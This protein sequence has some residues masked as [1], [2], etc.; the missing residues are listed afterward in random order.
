MKKKLD[1]ETVLRQEKQTKK[2]QIWLVLSLSVPAILAQITSIAMQYIDA[3]MVGN[4]GAEATAAIGLVSTSTW[5]VGGTCVGTAAGF[6]VQVAQ[7]VGGQR[8][9]E[10]RDVL[11]QG[12]C[13]L[14]IFGVLLAAL[15]VAISGNLPVW[16]G[17]EAEVLE[18]A[19]KYFFVYSLGIPFMQMR[20]LSASVMQCSGDM[21]TPSFL[22]G[23]LC[24]LDVIFNAFLIFPSRTVSVFGISFFMPG[25]GLRVVGAALGSMLSEVVIATIMLFAVC[26]RS[27]K[28]SLRQPGSWKWKSSTFLAAAKVTLPMTLD[29]IFVCSAYVVSTLIVAPLGT[30]AVAANSLAITA[31]SLVY[32]PGY[33][34]GSAATV[35]IG[36]TIGAKRRDLSKTFSRLS[37]I[38]GV[39]AMSALAV[40]MYVLAPNIFGLLTS[41]GEV[42]RLGTSVLRIELFVE[43]FYAAAICSNGV[44]RGAGDTLTPGILNLVSMWGVRIGLAIVLVP[45][46]GLAGYWIAMSVELCFR[47][48]IFVVRMLHGR[49]LKKA[50]LV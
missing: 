25:A 23:M 27:K 39:I 10:A 18:D 29:H 6:S 44:F 45:M 40:V 11:R 31:E 22:A 2:E 36:Q 30:L 41:D 4:M 3:G 13:A 5:L 32:M 24:V 7:L 9:A 15:G 12:L 21:K 46:Y 19:S 8:E 14:L 37:V 50:I 34:I 16:L 28:M 38:L 17:G 48:I 49:W 43:P 47:G 33:G 20:Q 1:L 35:I 42:A 26:I